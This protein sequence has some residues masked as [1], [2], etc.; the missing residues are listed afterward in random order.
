M[1]DHEIRQIKLD[2]EGVITDAMTEFNLLT[3]EFMLD[4]GLCIFTYF[5]FT[6]V[7]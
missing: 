3:V 6:S 1:S 2:Q 5:V 4:C 7:F